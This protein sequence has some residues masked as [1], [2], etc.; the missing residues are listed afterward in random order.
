M[1]QKFNDYQL[2][3]CIEASPNRQEP[4]VGMRYGLDLKSIYID[5]EGDAYGIIYAIGSQD[6]I[7]SLGYRLLKHFKTVL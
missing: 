2:V 6:K 4:E 1:D 3:E 5:F 7:Y